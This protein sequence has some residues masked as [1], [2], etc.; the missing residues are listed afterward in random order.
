MSVGNIQVLVIESDPESL[1]HT[2]LNIQDYQPVD[3]ITTASN[4]DEALVKLIDFTPDIILLEY[5]VKGHVG[6]KFLKYI[7]SKLQGT[8]VIYVSD[9]KE[10]AIH[11]IHDG[12]FNYL[13]KPIMPEEL[14]NA[15]NKALFDKENNIQERFNQIIDKTSEEIKLKFQTS[16][17]YLLV[18][19]DEIIFCRASSFYTELILTDERTELCFLLLSKIEQ[20][21]APYDFIRISLSILVNC[22][23]IRR[24]NRAECSVTLSSGGK[25]HE[26]KGSK[27]Q[28]KNLCKLENE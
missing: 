6:N 18:K 10:N 13:L 2:V 7:N 25:E 5:P 17:G 4:C 11:A 15:L 1:R 23:H 3:T 27:A 24:I 14:K 12:V 9:S 26:V 20:M 28:I 19:P 16:K 21:L 8:N 22:R